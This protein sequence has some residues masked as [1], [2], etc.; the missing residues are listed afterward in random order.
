MSIKIKSNIKLDKFKNVS[1]KSMN[2]ALEKGS[3]QMLTWA[4]NGSPKE[5]ATPPIRWGVLRGSSSAFV[6]DKSTYVF[7]QDVSQEATEDATP[8]I[9]YKGNESTITIVYNV[10]YAFK[11]HEEK[12]KSWEQLGPFSEQAKNVSDKWLEKH[13]AADKDILFEMIAKIVKKGLSNGI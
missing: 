8:A 1:K 13:L 7:P 10:N 5:S 4:N 12:G 3:I 2:N 6:G 11:M 9:S